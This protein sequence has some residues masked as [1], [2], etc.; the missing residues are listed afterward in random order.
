MFIKSYFL[1]Y[2]IILS[3][4]LKEEKSSGDESNVDQEADQDLSSNKEGG[5][6]ILD[7]DEETERVG[8]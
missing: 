3:L 5:A 6:V 8:A 2:L 4:F 7:P 1:V